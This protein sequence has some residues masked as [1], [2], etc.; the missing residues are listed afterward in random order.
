MDN[1]GSRSK[2]SAPAAATGLSKS[3]ARSASSTVPPRSPSVV[4]ST[5]ARRPLSPLPP[6]QLATSVTP[7]PIV[8]DNSVSTTTTATVTAFTAPLLTTITPPTTPALTTTTT[9]ASTSTTSPPAQPSFKAAPA[10]VS[11]PTPSSSSLSTSAP[12]HTPTALSARLAAHRQLIAQQPALPLTATS[13]AS[14]VTVHPPP[15]QRTLLASPAVVSHSAATHCPPDSPSL[16]SVRKP[17]SPHRAHTTHSSK[18]TATT[19]P[20]R[21][22]ATTSTP[23]QT[24]HVHNQRYIELAAI[25]RGATSKVYRVINEQRTCYALKHITLPAGSDGER[26]LVDIENEVRIMQRLKGRERCIQLIDYERRGGCC[27]MVLELGSI[28]LNG[29]MQSLS[30]PASSGEL[31]SYRLHPIK[32]RELWLAMLECVSVCHTVGVLHRDLKPANFVF[33]DGVMKIIDFGIA[34]LMGESDA[35]NP[36]AVL[37][38]SAMGTIN[39]MSP[40]S[41]SD[42]GPLVAGSTAGS[43]VRQNRKSDVWSLGCILYQLVYGKCPFADYVALHTKLRAITDERVAVVYGVRG[44]DGG[45]VGRWV[46]DVMQRCLVREVSDRASIDELL[47]HRFLNPDDE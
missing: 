15:A 31:D 5:A 37:S 25:G 7:A 40:E 4:Q 44:K 29:Y 45:V 8:A 16:P 21:P 24:F 26:G 11:P 33:V 19:V 34:A 9:A 30:R 10:V 42:N 28:D 3:P 43:G 17:T 46:L 14:S 12:T 6:T 35:A 47:R 27:Y 18:S 23:H 22:T 20:S 38:D 1:S 39:Y 41:L 36:T 13:L 2:L 32:L